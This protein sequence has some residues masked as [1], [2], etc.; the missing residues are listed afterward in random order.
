MKDIHQ[1]SKTLSEREQIA[2]IIWLVIGIMQI[3]SIVCILA[4]TWNV[5]AAYTRFTQS[6]AVLTPWVGIVNSYE[7]SL[8]SSIISI[9][10]NLVFGGVIG[11]AGGLYDIFMVRGYV[12]ENKDVYEQAGY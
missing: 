4:G 12:L 1:V 8:T 2:A 10:I 5:Y 9:V 3:L 6:K 11:V 7:N